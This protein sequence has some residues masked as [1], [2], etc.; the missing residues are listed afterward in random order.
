[1]S[2]CEFRIF[3]GVERLQDLGCQKESVVKWTY[4]MNRVMAFGPKENQL[5][6]ELLSATAIDIVKNINAE[7]KEGRGWTRFPK[8]LS[9][10]KCSILKF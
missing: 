10:V 6:Y 1:M 8:N 7:K 5:F 9:D 2:V 4:R 3:C